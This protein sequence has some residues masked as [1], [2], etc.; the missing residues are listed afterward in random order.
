MEGRDFF[1]VFPK[2][3]ISKDLKQ[4][5]EHV[6]VLKVAS[7][8]ARTALRVYTTSDRLIEKKT[9]LLCKMKLQNR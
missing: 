4:I 1:S 7:N 3:N 8:H 6:K 9:F 5:F 2:L